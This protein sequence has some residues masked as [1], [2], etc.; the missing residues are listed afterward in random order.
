MPY[1][2]AGLRTVFELE[3]DEVR[4]DAR[5][6]FA[7]IHPED[8]KPM[9]AATLRSFETLEPWRATYRVQLPKG[10]LR[11][12]EAHSVAERLPDGSVLWTGYIVDITERK[13]DRGGSSSP[14]EAAQRAN[15]REDRVPVAHEP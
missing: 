1:V 10:G 6:M 13:H 14:R 7:R 12:H 11:W 4:D 3:P 5:K 15:D 9:W 8:G 2:S